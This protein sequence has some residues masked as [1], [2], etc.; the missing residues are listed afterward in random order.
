MKLIRIRQVA[1]VLRQVSREV[2]F[3]VCLGLGIRSFAIRWYTRKLD[4]RTADR[5]DV[6]TKLAMLLEDG[7]DFETAA[8]RFQEA[9]VLK[10]QDSNL[11]WE[12]GCLRE[13]QGKRAEAVEWYERALA[14]PPVAGETAA[15]RTA[16][17]ERIRTLRTSLS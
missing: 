1:W 10:P 9:L 8:K 17:A 3:V 7:G 11:C 16:L 6:L 15:F 14:V 12:L 2:A 4:D 5:F 13:N